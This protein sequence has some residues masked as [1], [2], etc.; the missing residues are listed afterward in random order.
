MEETI[1]SAVAD[2]AKEPSILF[3]ILMGIGVVFFGLV[4][5]I[6]LC[7]LM[8]KIVCAL[9]KNAP[10]DEAPAA[11][12]VPAPQAETLS[13]EKRR[14]IIAAVSAVCAEELGTDVS[15]IRITS[16]KRI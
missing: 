9:E 6:I 13:P 14:E 10:A 11:K 4:C 8:S 12:A 1:I 5:I 7:T 2:T 15:A 3:V 16:F